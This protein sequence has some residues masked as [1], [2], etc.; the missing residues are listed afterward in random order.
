MRPKGKEE[1][2][3]HIEERAVQAI[4]TH[5]WYVKNY[6]KAFGDRGSEFIFHK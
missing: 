6:E 5:Y 3:Y 1:K 2:I 4:A